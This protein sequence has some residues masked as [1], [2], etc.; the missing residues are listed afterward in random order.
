VDRRA[1]VTGLGAVLAAPL[2]A[3]AQQVG[4]VPVIGILSPAPEAASPGL[5]F[6]AF[7]D[8]LGKLGYVDGQ[9]VR[10]E[11]RFAGGYARLDELAVELARLPVDVIVTDGGEPTV[12]AAL[13]ATKTIPIVMGTGGDPVA[14][15][16][17]KSLARPG[18]TVTGFTLSYNELAGKRL[19]LLKEMI[20]TATRI[21]VLWD[22]A[23]GGPQ[24]R[25]AE[26]AARSLGV[27]L[28]SLPLRSPADLDAVF[29]EAQR[30]RVG[31]LLGLASRMLFD[32]RRAI[33]DR[34]FAHRL[35]GMF[36]AG[37]VTDGGLVAYGPSVS[38]NF[39]GAAG[40]VDKILKGARAGDLPVESPS[41]F[42]LI[43]NLKTA[44][45]LGLTIP[46]S[47]L[48]RADQVIE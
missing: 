44:K 14:S 6:D 1:F 38:D 16:L 17:V 7:R 13:K 27:Q 12:H 45:A 22:P 21:G 32:N 47:L 34:A 28:V 5:P 4:R 11:F 42:Y 40:Y 8:A 36:D 2:A 31:A 3:E 19:Q 33:L 23:G 30:Q 43:I 24:L 26:A 18:G 46:P 9:N 39:R 29:E 10:L 41:K 37:S 25:A 15:G 35:P 48:L 20:P